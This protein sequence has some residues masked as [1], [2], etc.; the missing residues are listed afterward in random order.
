[1]RKYFLVQG[2]FL[3]LA[4]SSLIAAEPDAREVV[5]KVDELY[6]SQSSYAEME[7]EISTPHWERTLR[8]KAWTQGTDRTFIRITAPAKEKGVATLRVGNEM[9]NYLPNTNKVIKIPPSMMM[10]SWMGSDFTNND[11]VSEFTLLEDYN[12]EL[13]RPDTARDDLLYIEAIPKEGKPIVWG[14]QII[15]VRKQ[16]YIPVRQE[17]YSEDGELM[18]VLLYRDITRFD[19]RRI[20]AEMVMLPQDEEGR[21]VIRYLDAEFNIEVQDEIFSLRNLRSG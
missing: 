17:Y 9:W 4:V 13:A 8:M 11:L 6:R 3:L 5:R 1:M 14:K 21:T 15:Q 20:P 16:D 19:E 10:N 2:T 7:M 18:R 12:F